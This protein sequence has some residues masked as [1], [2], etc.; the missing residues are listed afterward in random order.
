MSTTVAQE[1]STILVL[2][3]YGSSFLVLDGGGG[4]RGH[5]DALS[6]CTHGLIVMKIN[7]ARKKIKKNI[8]GTQDAETSQ[9]FRP[10]SVVSAHET[11][12]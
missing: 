5:V 3:L 11:Y 6:L 2:F 7:R 1:M 9:V 8:P 10:P 12:K 4:V